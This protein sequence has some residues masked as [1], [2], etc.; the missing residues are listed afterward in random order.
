MVQLSVAHIARL[1]KTLYRF[2]GSDRS[3]G[4]AM[5]LEQFNRGDDDRES[6]SNTGLQRMTLPGFPSSAHGVIFRMHAIRWN[7]HVKNRTRA[8]TISI[9]LLLREMFPGVTFQRLFHGLKR[10]GGQSGFKTIL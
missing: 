9:L 3:A 1:H 10:V 6:A 8:S 5:G 4:G 7:A 2:S